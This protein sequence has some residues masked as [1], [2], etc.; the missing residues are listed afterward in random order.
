MGLT[1]ERRALL[2]KRLEAAEEAQF[3][4]A[5]GAQ[6]RVFV[7]QNGERIEFAA[8]SPTQ[9][10]KFIYLLKIELGLAISGPAE[11]WM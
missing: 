9:L 6:A 8:M 11:P 4:Y 5:T 2:S 1:T 7:D 10:T 3:Q